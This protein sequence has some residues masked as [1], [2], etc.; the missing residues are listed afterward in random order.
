MAFRCVILCATLALASA[1][2]LAPSALT[3]A[4]APL[5]YSAPAITSQSSNIYRSAGNL[6][7]ISTYSK[8]IDTPFSS[9]RK[10]DV[11]ISNPGLRYAAAP[12]IA[13]GGAVAAP[14]IAYSGAVAAPIAR[15]GPA[16]LLGATYS[17][18]PAVAHVVFDSGVTHYAF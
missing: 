13:Y 1:G 14:T 17:A 12:T 15:V 18:A 11:R 3:Y 7:Q 9:V 10:A 4:S 6:G 16:P 2:F 5:S 8:S